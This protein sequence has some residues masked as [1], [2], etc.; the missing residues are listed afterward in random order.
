MSLLTGDLVGHGTGSTSSR[1]N[2]QMPTGCECLQGEAIGLVGQHLDRPQP[3]SC[4][5]A[6]PA[7]S[8][9]IFGERMTGGTLQ[10]LH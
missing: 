3:A 8:E 5:A 9:V 1:A 4:V 7:D 2:D 6:R 10:D